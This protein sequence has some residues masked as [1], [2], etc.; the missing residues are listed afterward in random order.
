M[1]GRNGE[2]GAV[3][4]A[5]LMVLAL[6]SLLGAGAMLSAT[7]DTQATGNQKES[8]LAAYAAE[9]SLDYA[10]SQMLDAA[11]DPA[12]PDSFLPFA[13]YIPDGL[14]HAVGTVP[15]LSNPIVDQYDLSY[16]VGLLPG[17]TEPTE[18]SRSTTDNAQRV[19]NYARGYIV[20]GIAT[21]TTTGASERVKE[22]VRILR[23]PLTQYLAFYEGDMNWRPQT[24][25][26]TLVGGG[27]VHAS[28]SIYIAPPSG[29]AFRTRPPGTPPPP[30][31]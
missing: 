1:T 14:E 8:R 6:L 17:Q 23:R 2:R 27:R 30:S 22:T 3:L 31:P 29:I 21:N 16:I 11:R 26:V 28:G 9:A 5:V 19:L 18:V 10:I 24:A 20:T 4:V 13:T 7:L 25:A 15:G 12:D